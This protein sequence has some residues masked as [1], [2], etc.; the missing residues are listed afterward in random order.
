[1]KLIQFKRHSLDSFY[2]QKCTRLPLSQKGL[3]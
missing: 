3:H 1:M 2:M